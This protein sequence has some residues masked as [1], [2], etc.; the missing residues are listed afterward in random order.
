MRK[1]RQLVFR[2]IQHEGKKVGFSKYLDVF[3]ITLVC[4][5]IIAVILESVQSIKVNFGTFFDYF[6]TFSIVFFTIE[7]IFRIWSI[8]EHHKYRH[9]VTGRL[10]FACTPMIMV[11]LLAIIPFYFTAIT[12]DLR[13]LRILHVFRFFHLFRIASYVKA[14]GVISSVIRKKKEQLVLSLV[15]ILFMLTIA[16]CVMFHLEHHAQPEKF[17]SI[18]ETMWWG[19]ITFTTIG[20]GDMYPITDLGRILGG[21]FCMFGIVCFALPTGILVSGFTNHI[22]KE[23][24]KKQKR[25]L[26]EVY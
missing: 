18:P 5:N 22:E 20:Y 14:L 19:I 3:L 7:Y 6:E 26:Q 11:D 10:R 1:F 23:H 12:I 25:I 8:V 21:V 2:T 17:S 16:S 24:K 13:H 4:L 15:F 9:P